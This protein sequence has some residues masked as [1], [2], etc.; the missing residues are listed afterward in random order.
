[1]RV[2][3][4]NLI[5]HLVKEAEESPRKR[6]IFRFHQHQELV[7]RMINAIEPQSYVPPHKHERPNKVEAFII[8]KGK[9]AILRFDNQGEII[10]KVVLDEKGPVYG[11]DIQPGE[12]HMMVGLKKHSVVYEVIQGPYKKETHKKFAAWAP[13]EENK[14]EA[15]LYLE[16]IR[17]KISV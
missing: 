5:S 12:W 17:E 9:V 10:Q 14:K 16:K 13:L 7:Q 3:D 6:T 2:I 4:K 1:M 11:V 8:L 15:Q